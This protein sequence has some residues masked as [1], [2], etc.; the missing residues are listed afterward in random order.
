MQ[1]FYF[2]NSESPLFSIYHPPRSQ[3]FR[4]EGVV[5][6]YPIVQEY[7]RTHWAFRKL[8]SLLSGKGFHVLRFDFFGTGDSSGDNKEASISRWKDDIKAAVDELKDISGVKKVSLVGLRFG[9]TLAAE[10]TTEGLSVKNLVLWDPVVKG[11]TH[12]KE[13]KAMHNGLYDY[14]PIPRDEVMN[15]NVEGLLGV[16]LPLEIQIAIE[17]INLLTSTH[18]VAEEIFIVAS[19]E[20]SEYLQF[21][22]QLNEAGV[23]YDY[24]FVPD[25]CDWRDIEQFFNIH[26]VNN[27]LYAITAILDGN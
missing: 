3:L 2:G 25:V 21:R 7:M 4:N 12:L 5:L 14:L 15:E 19:E 8:S 16:P 22:D 20:R 11:R 9:A 26:L 6:V 18:C 27:I 1:P 23:K 10:V 24:H 13:L 17:Q